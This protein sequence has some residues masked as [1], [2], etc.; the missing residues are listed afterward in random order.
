MNLSELHRRYL[1]LLGIDHLPS[2]LDGLRL[3]VRRHLIRVPFEN[4]SKLLLF[5]REGAGRPIALSEFL[6]GIEHHDLGGTCYTSGIPVQPGTIPCPVGYQLP[7][8]NALLATGLD[9]TQA[10]YSLTLPTQDFYGNAIP[11]TK[12]SGYNIGADGATH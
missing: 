9:L 3:V 6:D 4:L 7:T 1:R 8:G 12:G 5:D 2:G 11:H 10:P